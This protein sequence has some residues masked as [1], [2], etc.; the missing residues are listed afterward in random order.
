MVEVGPKFKAE[1]DG[2]GPG[3]GQAGCVDLMVEKD[4]FN[5]LC[6]FLFIPFSIMTI[7][8]NIHLLQKSFLFKQLIK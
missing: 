2:L 5:S 8:F 4:L 3:V 7:Y 6:R 1:L